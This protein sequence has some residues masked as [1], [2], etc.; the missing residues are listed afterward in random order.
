M[1]DGG[2][3]WDIFYFKIFPRDGVPVPLGQAR[4]KSG[5]KKKRGGWVG[6]KSEGS[7]CAVAGRRLAGLFRSKQAGMEQKSF[8]KNHFY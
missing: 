2:V 7:Y 8:P 1:G 4:E 3:D 5:E 6:L